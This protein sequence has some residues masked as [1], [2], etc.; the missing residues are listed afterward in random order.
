MVPILYDSITEGVVPTHYGIG[1]L[2]DALSC[3]VHEVLNGLDELTLSYPAQG[4]HAED[5]TPGYFIKAKP[6]FTDDPQIFRIYKVGKTMAGK[7]TVNARHISYDLG[8]K[9]ITTGSAGSCAAAC[10]LL[11]ASAGNFIISTNKTLSGAFSVSQPASV[12]S[13][14]GGKEGSILDVYG[15]GE[16]KYDNYTASFLTA[17]GVDR[18]VTIRYGKNLTQ[19]SQE[20]DMTN[21][22]TGIY[23]FYIDPN[24]NQTIGDRV[25]TDLILDVDRDIAIDFSGDVDPE[26][27]TSIEDQLEALANRYIQNNNLTTIANSITLDFVQMKDIT[28]RVDLG[29]TVSIYFEALGISAKAKCVET[30]WDVLQER[31]TKTTFGKTRANITD[32]IAA[33]SMQTA[34][35]I[36]RQEMNEAT[37]LITGNRGGYVVLEDTDG[38]GK[39]DEILIMDTAD[40]NTATKVWRW[41]KSG[42]G[43]SSNGYAGPYDLAMTSAGEIDASFLKVGVIQDQQGNST[44]DMTNGAAVLNELKAKRILTLVDAN[45]VNRG[46]FSYTISTGAAMMLREPSNQATVSIAAGTSNDATLGLM[47]SGGQARMTFEVE[48]TDGSRGFFY[49]ASNKE[50]IRLQANWGFIFFNPQ[51]YMAAAV[52][53]NNADGGEINVYNAS[54]TL[55]GTF[56]SNANSGGLIIYNNSNSIIDLDGNNGRVTCVSLVQTSS[57]KVK[58][59]IKPM[60]DSAKILELDAVSFDFKDKEQGTDRRGFIAEDV[61]KV[62]PNLVKQETETEPAALDYVGMIPYLQDII[63]KQEARITALEEK[64]KSLEG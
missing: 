63:K 20:L 24:G 9:I 3:T 15:P 28:E 40:K 2:T 4:I 37:Q 46:H 5:I 34:Q 12:R 61:E 60:A 50:R 42:L 8:G 52:L 10:A 31:Y 47:S 57:R 36:T 62:L 26:S 29:D 35:A 6:N 38:D 49:D 64:I 56:F 17:R 41:N 13:W 45:G 18:S 54:G 39:P 27:Q 23:P 58:E 48:D 11:S 30:V 43:Y 32:T 14:F 22:V 25:P 16:W 1:P 53:N 19:L 44:I 7:F 55:T 21:L 59:N 33:Q 51:H